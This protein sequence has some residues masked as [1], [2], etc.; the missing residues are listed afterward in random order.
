VNLRLAAGTLGLLAALTL[1]PPVSSQTYPVA[2]DPPRTT[3]RSVLRGIALQREIHERFERGLAAES[4]RAWQEAV[5]EF[6]RIVTLDPAEPKGSTARYDLAIAQAQ[7][8]EYAAAAGNFEEALKRDPGFTAAA[9][10]LVTVALLAGD[11]KAARSAADRFV[12]LAPES[13]RARYSRGLVALRAGDLPTARADFRALVATD[14]GYAIAHYD[15][16]VVEMNSER[17][18]AAALELERA[19]QLSPGYARARFALGVVL[20][21]QGRRSDAAAAFGRAAQDASDLALR[22]AAIDMRN[23]LEPR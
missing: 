3:D 15:L 23:Q 6:S 18:D 21:K 5:S 8:G 14:P 1:A 13:A 20:V 4:R 10:N 7:L 19:L 2:T 9:A 17:Y 12:R 11:L 22:S 16:A